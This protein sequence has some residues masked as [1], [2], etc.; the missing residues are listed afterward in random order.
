[1]LDTTSADERAEAA[2]WAWELATRSDPPDDRLRVAALRDYLAAR[3]E[4]R[5]AAR[6]D[7]HQLD[8]IRH[9]LRARALGRW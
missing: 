5:A 9:E 6:L 2:A 8:A 1:M 7:I 3:R 4:A